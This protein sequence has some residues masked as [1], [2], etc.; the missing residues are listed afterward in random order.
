MITAG[1]FSGKGGAGVRKNKNSGNALVPLKIYA[2]NE[3]LYGPSRAD[4]WRFSADRYSRAVR[5]ES[6]VPAK[7]RSTAN[8]NRKRL[9]VWVAEAAAFSMYLSLD[10]TLPASK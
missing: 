4:G 8:P 3:I 2:E 9:T 5:K 6:P 1:R 7:A 10:M